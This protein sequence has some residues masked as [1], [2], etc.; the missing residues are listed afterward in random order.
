MV[1]L[2]V[3]RSGAD[4]FLGATGVVAVVT[5]CIPAPG[6]VPMALGSMTPGAGHMGC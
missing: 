2:T 5:G 6:G 1:V 4:P 3:I